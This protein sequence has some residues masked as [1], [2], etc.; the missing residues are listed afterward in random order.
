M[1]SKTTASPVCRQINR[2]LDEFA[3]SGIR[4]TL[5]ELHDNVGAQL[6][7]DVHVVFRRPT[8]FVTIIDGSERYAVVIE[9]ARVLKGK[10]LE[11][12]RI[13]EHWAIVGT[14]LME[15]TRLGNQICAR[16]HCQVVGVRQHDLRTDFLQCLRA[17]A[18]HRSAGS[19]RHEQ[20]GFNRTVRRFKR[21]CTGMTRLSLDRIFK[22]SHYSHSGSSS[23]KRAKSARVPCFTDSIS[24]PSGSRS[25][26]V[27]R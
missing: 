23:T 5:V 3:R 2:T 13:G 6:L 16:A 27:T 26:S 9:L 4:G 14:K 17:N 21:A 22:Q 7:L 12:T 10:D 25:Q 18:L 20:R 8:D 1:G 24:N 11:S 19:N 15:A